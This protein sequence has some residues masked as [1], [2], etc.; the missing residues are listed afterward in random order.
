M[1][2]LKIF[3]VLSI[4][5]Q[6]VS[7][8]IVGFVKV[9][10][11]F[12]EDVGN[13]NGIANNLV[14]NLEK[15]K[16]CIG[17]S[18]TDNHEKFVHS[19]GNSRMNWN[20]ESSRNFQEFAALHLPIDD[21]KIS[22]HLLLLPVEKD[23]N[24]DGS[25]KLD[26]ANDI[27]SFPLPLMFPREDRTH[28]VDTLSGLKLKISL[29]CA[30]KFYGP[31]CKI[32]CDS[33][34]LRQ[35]LTC[36]PQT[37][38]IICSHGWIG[39]DCSENVFIDRNTASEFIKSRFK[40]EEIENE[41]DCRKITCTDEQL[42]DYLLHGLELTEETLNMQNE[43]MVTAG[44]NQNGTR[45]CSKLNDEEYECVCNGGY[46][47]KD[48]SE[49]NLCYFEPCHNDGSCQD[50]DNHVICECPDGFHGQ[51]CENEVNHCLDE[52]C[53]YHGEC[54]SDSSGFRCL[55][56]TGFTGE[57]CEI[58]IDDCMENSCSNSG[59]C[60]DGINSYDC[61]CNEGYAGKNCESLIDGCQSE[62]CLN[63]GK[64]ES[65]SDGLYECTCTESFFGPT[66]AEKIQDP[67]EDDTCNGNGRCFS[68]FEEES[69]FHEKTVV[70]NCEVG[71]VGKYCQTKVA[72]CESVELPCPV[73]STC[74]NLENEYICVCP[75]GFEGENCEIDCDPCEERNDLKCEEN[76]CQNDARCLVLNN[77]V[78]C[79]CGL[80]FTGKH[81]ENEVDFC[82]N[83]TCEN[84]G[85]CMPIRD[86]YHCNCDEGYTG[87]NCEEDV[88][89][90]ETQHGLCKNDAECINTIGGFQCICTK[91]FAGETCDH[92]LDAC[93]FNNECLNGATCIPSEESFVCACRLGY[94]GLFCEKV[95]DL[96]AD[97]PS[98]CQNNGTCEIVSLEEQTIKCTC[99][100][101]YYG[102]F[103]EQEIPACKVK[104]ELGDGSH[105]LTDRT[106]CGSYGDCVVNDVNKFSCECH[107]GYEGE[108][109]DQRINVVTCEDVFCECKSVIHNYKALHNKFDNNTECFHPVYGKGRCGKE[110]CISTNCSN[111]IPLI[112]QY[113]ADC[114]DKN[115]PSPRS[116]RDVKPCPMVYLYFDRQH[117]LQGSTVSTICEEI[118]NMEPLV[119]Y[120]DKIVVKCIA[121]SLTSTKLKIATAI[122]QRS[123][124]GDGYDV[125]N[126]AENL[127]LYLNKIVI[128][129]S[130][131]HNESVSF[132]LFVA[133]QNAS[134][135]D[136][137]IEDGS[138]PSKLTNN[139]TN[140]SVNKKPFNERAKDAAII[141]VAVVCS[142]VLLVLAMTF[143]I[144][145]QKR[146]SFQRTQSPTTS[147][148]D[149]N[150]LEIDSVHWT[151]NGKISNDSKLMSFDNPLMNDADNNVF[152]ADENPQTSPS[153]SRIQQRIREDD[154]NDD[155]VSRTGVSTFVKN[156]PKS[157][158][159]R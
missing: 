41:Y 42:R 90:C 45:S 97:V 51:F 125:Y 65:F 9:Y 118:R 104:F 78:T 82:A 11:Y 99:H 31:R 30:E 69:E 3:V 105:E 27:L 100:E 140:D 21:S 79:V 8:D 112:C 128:N 139:N 19:C 4:Y 142:V 64:C 20:K 25:D 148:H 35:G 138:S 111:N 75:A 146:K 131:D 157:D 103:C 130:L 134:F 93:S 36:H 116:S 62:P 24:Q 55:C 15:I 53:G 39:D 135:N 80:G 22:T 57:K 101:R 29:E 81:C 133:L 63:G 43:C 85:E 71:Y 110:E 144:C 147:N 89:E 94:V 95:V 86:G 7:A 109:C 114:F 153:T 16:I 77:N 151:K 46:R 2:E 106:D 40:R 120:S 52:T 121:E 1:S 58:D 132:P 32:Y 50:I 48:C 149:N 23:I 38:E 126:L 124:S 12:E 26:G 107:E 155:T 56:D 137:F 66:C 122:K 61:D 150:N 70:C 17:K 98:P 47:G 119:S 14:E 156:S 76:P 74:V 54:E 115:K 141:A 13:E 88:N 92:K 91:G 33:S 129:D 10:P 49:N 84:Q 60:V 59:K 34:K 102:R 123:G 68:I 73:N 87:F 72:S 5:L 96:C 143:M 67:C 136:K 6:L 152:I 154:A 127:F 145:L 159:M 113:N 83:I 18:D 37:G 158:V 117:I 28:I 108:F 44:C